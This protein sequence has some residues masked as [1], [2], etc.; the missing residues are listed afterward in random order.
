MLANAKARRL[1]E[2]RKVGTSK[3]LPVLTYHSLDDSGSAIS[4]LPAQ[5]QSQMQYL[6]ENGWRTL[7]LDELLAGHARG[8]WQARTFALTFDDGFKNFLERG[9][10]TLTQCKFSAMLFVVSNWVG[11]TSDWLGQP[12]WVPRFELLDWQDLRELAKL[13]M[14]LGSHSANHARLARMAPQDAETAIVDCK[15]AIEDHTGH[16]VETFAYPYGETSRQLENIVAQNFRVGF[17]TR[18]GFV[19]G[20]DRATNFSR[21]E[22]YYFREARRLH[23]LES[24]GLEREFRVRR[25]LRELSRRWNLHE[26]HE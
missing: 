17:G 26:G 1:N 23:E 19:T 8:E 7:T 5:F 21:I 15:H 20:N 24:G 10:P 25:L 18:L 6:C 2:I 16:S 13:G 11:K 3:R 9:L 4:T 22:M 12:R 14:V